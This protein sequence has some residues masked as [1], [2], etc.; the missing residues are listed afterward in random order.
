MDD[1]TN[2]IDDIK[3]L[4][5]FCLVIFKSIINFPNKYLNKNQNKKNSIDQVPRLFNII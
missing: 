3:I 5:S 1:L 2:I 4:I